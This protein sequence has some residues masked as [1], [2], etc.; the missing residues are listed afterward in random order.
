ML[1]LTLMILGILGWKSYVGGRI[2]REKGNQQALIWIIYLQL[3][4]KL[5][6]CTTISQW[7]YIYTLQFVQH[8]IE[9][10]SL[11]EKLAIQSTP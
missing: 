6:Q 5:K 1:L 11:D 8:I 9:H 7:L 3:F 10:F 2:S 4:T